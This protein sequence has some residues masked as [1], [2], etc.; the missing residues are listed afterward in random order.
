[1]LFNVIKPNWA[2]NMRP[3]KLLIE[4]IREVVVWEGLGCA[5]L[6]LYK[7]R[8]WRGSMLQL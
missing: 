3:E 5:D 1:M 4:E 8:D 6:C 7:T 2:F